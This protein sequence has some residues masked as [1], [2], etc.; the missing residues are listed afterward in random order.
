[1]LG[2]WCRQKHRRGLQ[3]SGMR[4]SIF[5]KVLLAATLIISVFPA[6][7]ARSTQESPAH[8][9]LIL[10]YHRFNTFRAD[11]TTVSLSVFRFQLRYMSQHG[12]HFIPL[13]RYVAYRLKKAPPPP[14]HS[15]IITM[16]DGHESVYT[17]ALPLVE[18]YRIPVTLFI[19]PSAIS[20][21]SYAMTWKQLRVLKA[22]GLFDIQSH[23]YWHPN[24]K[25]EKRRLTPSQYNKFVDNQLRRSR[26]VL[27][28]ELGISVS[29]LAWPYGI[30]DRE[31]AHKAS[32]AG[33]TAAFGLDGRHAGTFDNIM[34][35][36]R[37][38]VTDRD[39]GRL[40]ED[41]LKDTPA[42]R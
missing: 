6:L 26:E 14:P 17:K 4:N 33:Y 15:V 10:D 41:I 38:M 30:Y 39:S 35:V 9:V 25:I 37:Y 36:S 13:S 12:Y 31:L 23:T 8:Q 29:M 24:F 40:F 19:Y 11:S 3:F 20:H 32:K 5:F 21:A 28:K 34:D 18:K 42:R 16:D 27:D 1:M 2:F 7:Q 22:T